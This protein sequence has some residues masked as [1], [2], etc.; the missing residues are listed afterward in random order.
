M[1]CLYK[2]KIPK[3]MFVNILFFFYILNINIFLLRIL[4]ITGKNAFFTQKQVYKHCGVFLLQY[5]HILKQKHI[6]LTH[7]Y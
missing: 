3:T 4:T 5:F 6:E 1:L 2:L 7:V